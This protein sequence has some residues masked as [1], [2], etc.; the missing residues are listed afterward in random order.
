MTAMF[1]IYLIGRRLKLEVYKLAAIRGAVAFVLAG[2]LVRLFKVLVG[3]PRPRLW[4]DGI[5]SL[6]PTFESGFDSFP[7]GHTTTI[8]AVALVLSWHFPRG[9]PFFMSAAALVAASRLMSGSHF[10]LDVL[11]GLALG[12]TVGWAVIRFSLP[13]HR[14][15]RLHEMG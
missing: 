3:R 10:P 6:G 1:I 8:M 13:P 11:G 2:L 15:R 4:E 7:S 9:A 5:F 12:L 14:E